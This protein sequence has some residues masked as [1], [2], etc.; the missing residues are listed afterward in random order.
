MS[1]TIR[2]EKDGEVQTFTIDGAAT[3]MVPS[4]PPAGEEG[5]FTLDGPLKLQIE[6]A[7]PWLQQ[8]LEVAISSLRVRDDHSTSGT[9]MTS[10]GKGQQVVVTAQP[11][12]DASGLVWRQ[13]VEPK[14]WAGN[15]I[16]EREGDEVYMQE[17]PAKTVHAG[18]TVQ[19]D[20]NAPQP[21]PLTG[22]FQLV[23]K[24]QHTTLAI[25]G[26][27]VPW[28]G[29]NIREFA[30]FGTDRWKHTNANRRGE[31]CQ[32]IKNLNMRWLRFF[33]PKRDF[34]AAQIINQVRTTLDEI[35]DKGL[36]A[37]VCLGDSLAEVDL[38]PAGDEAWHKGPMGH[39]IKDYYVNG[40]YQKNYL[41]LAKHVVT[42][43]KDHP[44]VGMWQ[45]LNEPGLYEREHQA[46]TI[47]A[48][49]SAAFGTFV[50]E[51]SKL[52]Y[53]IDPT[54]PISIGLINTAH[55]AT[56]G[57]DIAQFSKEFFSKRKYIH[58]VTCHCYQFDHEGNPHVRWE[59]EDNCVLDA[60]AAAATG[61][62]MMWTEFGASQQGSRKASTQRF[63]D[64]HVKAE[65]ASAALQWGFMLTNDGLDTGVGDER[66]GFSD[67][68]RNREF[69]ELQQLFK[70]YR[71]Q[72]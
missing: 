10:F 33:V 18:T 28:L 52:I 62:A 13:I 4:A 69:G 34:S 19:I 8:V 9:H 24:G 41:P 20:R 15:W 31:Y 64:E 65:R 22:R 35:A 50:D 6:G 51:A 3:L 25:D 71:A 49:Q 72:L 16:A 2:F 48:Q 26:D 1:F 23:N 66:Y 40:E 5:I 12:K 38:Y 46:N 63:L 45:L 37:V 61:R 42:E 29:V 32:Q 14:Q 44:G 17:A 11:V 21:A 7:V 36:L 53:E 54:H 30:Y 27:T 43:L 58:V 60:R 67:W 56:S 39:L 47:T 68:G 70:S 57:V 59:H 55:I